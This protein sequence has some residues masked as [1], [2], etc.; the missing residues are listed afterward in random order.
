MSTDMEFRGQ[1][2]HVRTTGPA[3]G[4]V[5]LLLHGQSFH[6]GTWEELGTLRTLA[7]HGLRAVAIDVPGYGQSE[8]NEIAPDAFLAELIPALGLSRPVIVAPSM[9]GLFAFP[10][11]VAH[12][13]DVAGFVPV[14]PAGLKTWLPQLKDCAVP[15]LVVWG[16]ED[17]VVPVA[18][19]Y[20]LAA[21]LRNS[22][23]LVLEGAPH[24]A[25]LEQPDEFHAALVE[26]TL[27]LAR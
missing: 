9:G 10:Y 15:T 25:Y 4:R 19:A 12:P 6:S 23:T 1:R 8:P 2:L 17:T 18:R 22:R 3:D 24:P 20:D 11:V 27:G 26:F 7:E 5:V 21:A 13:E 14:A 16:S